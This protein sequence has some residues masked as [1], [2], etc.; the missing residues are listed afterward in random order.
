MSN[1]GISSH[2]QTAS[3]A[4]L[5][6]VSTIRS[7]VGSASAL[8]VAASAT[9]AAGGQVGLDRRLAAPAGLALARGDDGKPVASRA[10]HTKPNGY[11]ITR[12]FSMARTAGA[13]PAVRMDPP[14][15]GAPALAPVDPRHSPPEPVPGPQVEQDARL[16]A[17]GAL[18]G[19]DHPV[20]LIARRGA[21]IIR[22][23]LCSG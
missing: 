23:G 7:R 2:W 8:T 12:W 21:G 19:D 17:A 11:C 22:S 9:A 15:A 6:S 3:G 10:D 13:S 20:T 18:P 5:R 1:S 4:A 16:P 14:R